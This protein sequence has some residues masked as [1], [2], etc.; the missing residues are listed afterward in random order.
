MREYL[1]KRLDEVRNS[2]E[3]AVLKEVLNGFFLPMYD[4][5]E[6]KY[7]ALER[8]VRAELPLMYDIYTVY[9]AVLPATSIDG[10][11]AYLSPMIPEETELTPLNSNDLAAELG[12][13]QYPA[14]M[15]VFMEADF[16]KCRRIERDQRIFSG[17][18]VIKSERYPFKCRLQPAKRYLR[19]L[20]ALYNA[21]IRNDVPWTTINAAYLNKFFDVCLTELPKALPRGAKITPE[22]IEIS[23]DPY[24]A[25]LK[26][27]LIPVWNI[28]MYR[29]KGED[30]PM[31][32]VDAVNYEYRF[33]LEKLGEENGF[34][35]D[36]NNVY[37]LSSRR[38]D[39]LLILTSPQKKGLNW[40]MFRLR[41]RR[42]SA[43]DSYLYPVLSNARRDSFSTR[44]MTKYRTH[45]STRAELYKL[46]TS[47]EAS[48]YLELADLHFAGEKMS[49]DTYDMNPFIRDEVRDPGYQKTLTL[50]FRARR[51]DFFLNRDIMSF[52][53][54]EF[55]SSYPEYRCVGALI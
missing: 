5:I 43:I 54:S 12:A 18:F 27:G 44:L 32:A 22:Q 34:L 49:G 24:E 52:L 55:Q 17:T 37:I 16:L 41:P 36:Y 38:E 42:D 31:P 15:T 28:D 10:L 35:L 20:D 46:L 3:K 11:H 7:A 47:F 8:R 33:E 29:I 25:D 45:I 23:F 19:Q 40:D 2:E 48:E 51:R 39:K 30:F 21:F 13:G 9:S 6:E 50:T 4:D 26:R 14:L 1:A 53:V